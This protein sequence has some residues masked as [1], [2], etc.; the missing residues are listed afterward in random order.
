M[1]SEVVTVSLVG[2]MYVIT[3]FLLRRVQPVVQVMLVGDSA[4]GKTCMLVRFKDETFLS[5]NFISTVGIDYRVRHTI[6]QLSSLI[7]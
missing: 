7:L 6:N 1:H 5:G 4:V 2:P 3:G